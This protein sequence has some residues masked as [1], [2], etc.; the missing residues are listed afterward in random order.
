MFR[1]LVE[2]IAPQYSRVELIGLFKENKRTARNY[3]IELAHVLLL[4]ARPIGEQIV[5]CEFHRCLCG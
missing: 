1:V 2:G 5:L 3:E 4:V